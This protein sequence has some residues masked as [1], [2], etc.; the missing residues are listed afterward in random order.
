M[1]VN[2]LF[3]ILASFFPPPAQWETDYVWDAEGFSWRVTW[4]ER[5]YGHPYYG[6]ILFSLD[7][8]DS[9]RRIADKMNE[10]NVPLGWPANCDRDIPVLESALELM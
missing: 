3:L 1:N 6:D 7:N 10:L 9:A 5:H 4:V 2:V 8:Y